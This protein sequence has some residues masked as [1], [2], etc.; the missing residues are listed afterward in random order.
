MKAAEVIDD[1]LRHVGLRV[2][3]GVTP[4]SASILLLAGIGAISAGTFLLRF[5]RVLADC[6]LLPGT[7]LSKFGANKKQP[8]SGTWAV[9][10]G[11]TDGIGRE[12]AL[13]LA[14]KG[15]NILLVSRT[16]EKL[17]AV[18]GEIESACAGIKTRTQAVDF[19]QGDEKQYA[20]LEETVR[21]LDVGVLVNNVGKS[22]DM[23]VPFAETPHDEME[24]IVEINVVATL[25]VSRMVVPGMVERRRGL[26]LNVGSFAGQTT[27]PLLATYA[28][29]KAFLSGWSQALG[30]E[31]SRSNVVVSL[32]N[33]YFVTS[34]LSKVRKSSSM[35]PTPKQYVAQ[36]LAKVGR[37]GGAVGRPYTSTPWP[38][39][40]LVDWATTY[41]VPRAWLLKF[42]YGQQ[43]ATRK[44]ALRK[45]QKAVKAQ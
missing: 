32:L 35:I 31:L 2:D 36:A 33:T 20:A 30:E 42:V 10:T 27:T 45:A 9:V 12:F 19:A 13:Q 1:A 21:T 18:A 39:H 14:K 44:R 25:R 43:V 16:P 28:G 34:K 26:V 11:A 15:F 8:G 3:H 38:G 4:L 5:A 24:D 6:Y 40:A 23:P 37:Q 22:H 29:S 17:G 7:S 41:V